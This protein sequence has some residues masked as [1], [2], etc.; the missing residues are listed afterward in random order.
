MSR[1][2][3]FAL[4]AQ[5][6]E[7]HHLKIFENICERT[8]RTLSVQDRLGFVGRIVMERTDCAGYVLGRRSF[9]RSPMAAGGFPTST[10]LSGSGTAIRSRRFRKSMVAGS[11]QGLSRTVTGAL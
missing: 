3:A 2:D 5:A 1:E 8:M 4:L 11:I 6:E 9:I 7:R 10:G